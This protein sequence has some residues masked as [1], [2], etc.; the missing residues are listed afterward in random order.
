MRARTRRAAVERDRRAAREA[1]AGRSCSPAS[2]GT[3]CTKSRAARCAG[4]HREVATLPG[5]QA[6]QGTAVMDGHRARRRVDRRAL[7]REI[8]SMLAVD[9]SPEFLARVRT[10]VADGSRSLRA[11]AVAMDVRGRRRGGCCDRGGRW[12]GSQVEQAPSSDSDRS[13]CRRS[14]KRSRH[15]RQWP[16]E[17]ERPRARAT[18]VARPTIRRASHGVEAWLRLMFCRRRESV[19]SLLATIRRTMSC[20]CSSDD[21]PEL[22]RWRASTLEDR[23]EP[24][25]TCACPE[26]LGRRRRVRPYRF[27]AIAVAVADAGGPPRAAPESCAAAASA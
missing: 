26:P 15:L 14:R 25:R 20:W 3:T 2:K 18:V 5:A 1:A 6:T 12:C 16:S 7:E 21:I 4:R 13:N 22:Q 11:V 27:L 17:V 9:P 8:E 24:H 10:R 23:A 19:R